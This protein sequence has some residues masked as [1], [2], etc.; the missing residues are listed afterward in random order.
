MIDKQNNMKEESFADLF[1]K[2]IENEDMVEGKVV[3]G[4]IISIENDTSN[5]QGDLDYNNVIN[6]LDIIQAINLILDGNYQING[7]INS[8]GLLNIIDI[9]LLVDI[10]VAD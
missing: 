9:V 5:F 6:I 10:I 7:D 4:K 3:K 1:A 2:H 8:D